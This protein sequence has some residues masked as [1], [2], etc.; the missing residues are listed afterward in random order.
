MVK[1]GIFT[2]GII[3]FFTIVMVIFS[4]YGSNAEWG[5]RCVSTSVAINASAQHAYEVLGNSENARKWSTVVHHIPSLNGDQF[6]DGKLG[7]KRRCFIREDETGK[8]WDEEIVIDE[9]AKK[10]RLTIY[11]FVDFPLTTDHLLTEQRYVETS[12]NECRLTF[13]LFLDEEKASWLGELKL[14]FAAYQVEG[15]FK[16]NL[17]N[18]KHLAEEG[19]RYQRIYPYAPLD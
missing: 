6:A 9:F 12:A 18:I 7:S 8:R 10:R 13:T 2:I 1:K 17:E 15:I 14:Y 3:S 11:N 16:K 5:Y 19:D 4:P